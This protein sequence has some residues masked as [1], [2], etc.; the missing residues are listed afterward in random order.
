MSVFLHCKIAYTTEENVCF[1]LL[2]RKKYY[3]KGLVVCLKS[4]MY[5]NVIW[6][7]S[8][9]TVALRSPPEPSCEFDDASFWFCDYRDSVLFPSLLARPICMGSGNQQSGIAGVIL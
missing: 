3:F 1:A 7:I 9:L 4:S 5:E 8:I 2:S 6:T